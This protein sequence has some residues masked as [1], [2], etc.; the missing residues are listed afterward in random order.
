MR[1]SQNH[2]SAHHQVDQSTV[3]GYQYLMPE[4]AGMVYHG[5]AYKM[6]EKSIVL[7]W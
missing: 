6:L 4:G 5:I 7:R 3:A 2:D 1:T